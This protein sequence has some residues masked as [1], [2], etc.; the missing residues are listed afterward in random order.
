MSTLFSFIL[1]ADKTSNLSFVFLAIRNDFLFPSMKAAET[2]LEVEGVI[3]TA[4]VESEQ[5]IDVD[6][7]P[8]P[9]VIEN[10]VD[11]GDSER[12]KALVRVRSFS[13]CIV[14]IFTSTDTLLFRLCK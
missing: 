9:V 1:F 5:T 2:G 13:R 11:P 14:L 12:Q 8:D 4:N 6:N 10:D 7:L 3:L